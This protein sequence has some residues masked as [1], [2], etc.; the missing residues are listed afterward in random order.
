MD[1]DGRPKFVYTKSG[2]SMLSAG[3]S[4][5]TTGELETFTHYTR[6]AARACDGSLLSGEL[7]VEYKNSGRGWSV[8]A[9]TV[10]VLE[11]LSPIFATLTG[12][13]ALFDSGRGTVAGRQAR[14]L[15][16]AWKPVDVQIEERLPGGG[17]SRRGTIQA[18]PIP[19][20]AAQH[21]WIDEQ[22]LLPLRWS[23]TM[24][25]PGAAT[26]LDYGMYFVFDRSLDLR[27]P[28]GV[29]TPTCVS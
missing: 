9:R 5:P 22:T 8:Q 1:S 27:P 20:D 10:D 17:L 7:V 12:D 16:A 11:P 21:L 14:D 24:T 29:G 19:A 6:Q 18:G 28:D 3:Q 23:I 2:F 4:Q 25:P 15:R 13:I 26:P